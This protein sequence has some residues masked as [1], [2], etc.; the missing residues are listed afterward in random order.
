MA[1]RDALQGGGLW[2]LGEARRVLLASEPASA[3][4]YRAPLDRAVARYAR[5][6]AAGELSAG[7]LV[8]SSEAL[9][10]LLDGLSAE[11]QGAASVSEALRLLCAAPPTVILCDLS[12]PGEDGYDFLRQQHQLAPVLAAIPWCPAPP[13]S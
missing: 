6:I 8:A 7:S 12:M 2:A 11:V 1:Q 5:D 13:R 3:E 9:L 4:R 10:G